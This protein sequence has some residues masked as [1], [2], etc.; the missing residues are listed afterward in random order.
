MVYITVNYGFLCTQF[1]HYS[2]HQQC[3]HPSFPRTSAPPQFNC[4][5]EFSHYVEFGL[6]ILLSRCVTFISSYEREHSVSSIPFFLT[7]FTQYETPAS[8]IHVAAANSLGTENIIKKPARIMSALFA[9]I[10]KLEKKRKKQ[11]TRYW[12]F[13]KKS[14]EG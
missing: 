12:G 8:S 10:V 6:I 13:K 2:H 9:E 4:V 3:L 5:D 7:D 14:I 11:S 1:Q